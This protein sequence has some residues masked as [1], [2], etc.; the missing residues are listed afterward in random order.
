MNE[1][2]FLKAKAALIKRKRFG[3]SAEAARIAGVKFASFR[4]WLLLQR[5]ARNDAR[6]LRALHK[7]IEVR[8]SET[9]KAIKATKGG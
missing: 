1:T 9:M 7:A 3:D 5:V 6:N 2:E 8:E 4:A